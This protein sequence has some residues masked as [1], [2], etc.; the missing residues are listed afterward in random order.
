VL[1]RLGVPAL[2]VL[3]IPS[4]AP[5]QVLP[6]AG[7]GIRMAYFSP[8]RAFALSVDGK[9]AQATLAALEA[10]TTRELSAR[11]AKLNDLREFI[12]KNEA[13]LSEAAR[14]QREIEAQRFELDIKR[15]VEDAHG[16]SGRSTEPGEC[17]PGEITAG[18]RDGRERAGARVSLQ[19]G[20]G[21]SGVGRPGV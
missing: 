1:K 16:V 3:V 7:N 20:F 11:T 4:A 12:R 5:A 15:F 14:Q 8:Q 13:V 18:T 21:A 9:A 17:L 19:R 2:L 6:V 10:E